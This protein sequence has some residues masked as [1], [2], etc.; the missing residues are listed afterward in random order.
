MRT[1]FPLAAIL[2][3]SACAGA[4]LEKQKK[5]NE[6]L[7]EK[8]GAM[9]VQIKDKSDEADAARAA[10]AATEAKLAETE[11]K[12]ADAE[13][14]LAI[15]GARIESLTKSNKDLSDAIGAS[16]SDLSGKLNG[17]IAEKDALA[18][19]LAEA[20][21]EKLILERA[22]NLY[23]TAR[24]RAAAEAAKTAA[25]R[26]ALAARLKGA[27]DAA[28]AARER[29]AAAAA[30]RHEDMGSVADVLLSE[31]QSGR[32]SAAQT[33][34]AFSVTLSNELLFD[35]GS[36]KVKDEGAAVLERVGRALK[37]LGP[38]TIDVESHA[39][40]APVK[41]GL[42]GGFED[43]WALT[44]ARAAAVSRWLHEHAGLDPAHLSAE[45]FG[46]F[47]PVK[48]NDTAE[49]RAANRRIVIEVEPIETP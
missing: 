7:R 2:L 14:R 11:G 36:A 8:A 9:L 40:N 27:D 23:R 30:K 13:S 6:E 1:L 3:L 18:G 16:Q 34:D 43:P 19:K 28:L 24:D 45:G 26:D 41:K 33:A 21:K 31:M 38:R 22:R 15:A 47:R 5:Q 49:G 29:A 37:A 35:D 44:A 39:D 20:Q 42:L 10:K 32:A 48:P 12:L 46:E 17:A 4:Q 25:E